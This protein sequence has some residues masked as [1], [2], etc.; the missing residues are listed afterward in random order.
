[1]TMQNT[2]RAVLITAVAALAGCSVNPTTGRNQLIALPAAQIAHSDLGFT[3]SAASQG[4]AISI[5]CAV[6]EPARQHTDNTQWPCA[7]AA[8][9]HKFS[10]QVERLSTELAVQARLLAPALFTRISNFQVE[11]KSNVIAGTSSSAGGRIVL[12]AGLATLDPTDDV[13]AFLIAREMGNV[14]ARHGEE[15]SGARIAFSAIT[16][17]I[18]AGGLLVKFAASMLGSQALKST[19]AEGQRQE[20]DEVALALLDLCDRTPSMITLNLQ[21]GMKRDSLPQGEWRTNFMRSIE[22]VAAMNR[23]KNRAH[24]AIAN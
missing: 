13:V 24:V 17:L 1:M 2:R 22:R 21:I 18:P 10:L 12:D 15:D 8:Q 16:A 7:D 20:S 11:V 23:T 5:P 4:P 3:F 6:A 19:W 14:I 9:I